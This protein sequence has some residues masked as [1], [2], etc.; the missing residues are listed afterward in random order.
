MTEPVTDPAAGQEP[1]PT[2]GA[3]EIP[4]WE[5]D[6]QPFDA[7]R[8]WKR[9][10]RIQQ[11]LKQ[12]QHERDQARIKAEEYERAKLSEQERLQKDL[13]AA[14]AER[15]KHAAEAMR[16]RIALQHKIDAE[17][18]DLLGSGS[19]EEMTARALRVA[20]KNAAASK[21]PGQRLVAYYPKTP[22][23][24]VPGKPVEQLHPGAAPKEEVSPEE[25]TWQALFGPATTGK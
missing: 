4:P 17:D 9:Q 5:R 3:S 2:P 11:D 21:T 6:G 12:A 22:G 24:P 10:Q 23:Q 16:V 14:Q 18:I 15:D 8:A 25:E 19:E 7:E 13:A 1:E 20:A